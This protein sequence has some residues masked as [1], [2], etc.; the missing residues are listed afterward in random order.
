MKAVESVYK[1][2]IKAQANH[3]NSLLE[4]NNRYLEIIGLS[5]SSGNISEAYEYINKAIE[6]NMNVIQN[7]EN[8]KE[9]KTVDE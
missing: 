5:I 8:G 3:R 1:D 9:Y 7:F 6:S 2:I 4:L